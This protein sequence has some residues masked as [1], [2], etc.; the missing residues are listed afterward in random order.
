MEIGEVKILSNNIAALFF[1]DSQPKDK[2]PQPY[3]KLE[4]VAKL[5][6]RATANK[7][8]LYIDQCNYTIVRRKTEKE[9]QIEKGADAKTLYRLIL[10]IEAFVKSLTHPKGIDKFFPCDELARRIMAG[11]VTPTPKKTGVD[12]TAL[13]REK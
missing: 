2:P 6:Y 1:Q 4:D 7:F 3:E 10:I 13:N 8:L 9:K 11:R 12:S 5:P